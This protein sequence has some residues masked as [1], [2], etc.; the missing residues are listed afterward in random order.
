MKIEINLEN[1]KSI[2]VAASASFKSA[3]CDDSNS[4]DVVARKSAIKIAERYLETLEE[5]VI[6]EI[7]CAILEMS[8]FFA[9]KNENKLFMQLSLDFEKLHDVKIEATRASMNALVRKMRENK[10]AA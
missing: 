2:I 3:K 4:S 10:V 9:A 5:T 1:A 6:I 7:A 8:K